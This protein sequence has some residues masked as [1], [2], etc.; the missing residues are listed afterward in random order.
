MDLALEGG[1]DDVDASLLAVPPESRPPLLLLTVLPVLC[2]REPAC[3]LNVPSLRR[4]YSPIRRD[5]GGGISE[6][7]CVSLCFVSEL[8]GCFFRIFSP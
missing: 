4:P 1:N 3:F 6:R 5:D 8:L 7:L 2:P